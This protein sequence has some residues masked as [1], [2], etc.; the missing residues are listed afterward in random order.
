M[1][2]PAWMRRPGR[3]WVA[4]ILSAA[5][6]LTAVPALAHAVLMDSSPKAGEMLATSP[7]EITASFNE[8]VGPIF[9]KI[10]DRSG[11]EVGD[12]GEIKLDG[13]KMILPLRATLPNGTY[14][15][16]YR[17]ISADTHPVGTTF[18]FSIGE[19]MQAGAALAQDSGGGKTAWTYAV[20]LN[21]CC[22][23]ARCCWRPVRHYSAC[24]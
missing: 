22:C 4:L 1:F 13:L 5:V 18:G 3:R 11:K 14:V 24:R 17:V 16:T 7:K 2:Q 6:S 8:S 9:F 20:A 12:A 23:I 21:R 15:F 19:P 10:L